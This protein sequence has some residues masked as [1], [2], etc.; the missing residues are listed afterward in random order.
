MQT[1]YIADYITEDVNR[2]TY[3]IA[4][5]ITEDVN[6]RTYY[7]ADYIGTQFSKYGMKGVMFFL[8]NLFLTYICNYDFLKTT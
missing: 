4:D 5:Y 8:E 3:Y 7:I 6:R 1:Y 2:R